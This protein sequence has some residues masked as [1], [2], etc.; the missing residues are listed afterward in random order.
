MNSC[1]SYQELISSLIDREL[2]QAEESRI[3]EHIRT[4]SQC[5]ALYEAFSAV[6]ESIDGSLEDP[7]PLL[8]EEIMAGVRGAELRKRRKLSP[9]LRLVL[10]TAAC[11][12]LVFGVTYGLAPALQRGAA[13]PVKMAAQAN[14]VP[15]GVAENYSF[16]PQEDCAIE[17][18]EACPA[19]VA[20]PDAVPVPPQEAADS[21]QESRFARAESPA[22][23][24]ESVRAL[25]G[26]QSVEDP[27]DLAPLGTCLLKD[28]VLEL[29]D[30]DG[31]ICYRL[32]AEGILYRT[33]L[34]RAQVEALLN[35]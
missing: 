21:L 30:L 2:S 11:A 13:A 18:E 24:T 15:Y 22:L 7:P 5:A 35:P 25:L 26:G 12:A 19:E 20:A 27:G 28:D 1:Q 33:D 29:Y 9:A 31:A 16:A 4:C 8:H 17:A 3:R 32:G 23:D 34:D 14:S 6:R 10:T